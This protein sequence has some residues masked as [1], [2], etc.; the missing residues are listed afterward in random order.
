MP[1]GG[2]LAFKAMAAALVLLSVLLLSGCSAGEE[3]VAEDD[4]GVAGSG[5]GRE[6]IAPDADPTAEKV[7]VY[8]GFGRDDE[9]ISEIVLAK[10]ERLASDDLARLIGAS[11]GARAARLDWVLDRRLTGLSLRTGPVAEMEVV[12]AASYA[13]DEVVEDDGLL[14]CEAKLASLVAQHTPTPTPQWIVGRE[15]VTTH[16]TPA[17]GFVSV[18][19]DDPTELQVDCIGGE[20]RVMM[21]FASDYGRPYVRGEYLAYQVDNGEEWVLEATENQAVDHIRLASPAEFLAT[22][23]GASEVRIIGVVHEPDGEHGPLVETVFDIREL[24]G[25]LSPMSCVDPSAVPVVAPVVFTRPEVRSGPNIGTLETVVHPLGAE[26]AIIEG[27]RIQE[28]ADDC[29]RYRSHTGT[30]NSSL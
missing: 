5:G 11:R 25:H 1:W 3:V 14:Y 30:W 4:A 12:S 2:L 27:W 26:A 29:T 22:L 6:V 19:D 28:E 23:D 8:R 20:W 13:I 15:S 9:E 17:E 16:G 18:D 21:G 10:Y 7:K 24:G